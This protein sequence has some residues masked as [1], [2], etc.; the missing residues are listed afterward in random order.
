MT[1]LLREVLRS[2]SVAAIA[3]I[4]FG[5]AFRALGLRV[6]EYGMALIAALFGD[7]PGGARFGLFVIEHFV[8]AWLAAIPL[9]LALRVAPKSFPALLLGASYGAGF[10]V[11]VNSLALP[12]LFGDPTPWQLGFDVIYPS[13]TLHLVYGL[14]VAFTARGFVQRD[15]GKSGTIAGKTK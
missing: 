9:L 4:P 15:A 12:W 13:L 10:Y 7:L 11:A 3:M 1:A 5:L 2:G 8:I 14:S 6:N